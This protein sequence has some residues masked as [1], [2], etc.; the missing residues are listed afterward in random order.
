[1]PT[2]IFYNTW[3]LYILDTFQKSTQ[4]L[5]YQNEKLRVKSAIRTSKEQKA[6]PCRSEPNCEKFQVTRK[7]K[8]EEDGEKE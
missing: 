7:Q 4:R 2:L 1:M 8:I 6:K 5:I 3:R